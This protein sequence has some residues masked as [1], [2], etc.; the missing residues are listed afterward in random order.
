[1]ERAFADRPGRVLIVGATGSIGQPLFAACR[2]AGWSVVGTAFRQDRPGLLHFDLGRDVLESVLPGA[3]SG[4]LVYL[5]SALTSPNAVA[6]NPQSARELNLDASCR[7]ASEVL[8]SGARLV[9][10]SSTQVFDGRT[11]GY[12]E[13]SPCSALTLYGQL[14]CEFEAFLHSRDGDWAL[15][16]TDAIVTAAVGSNCPVEKTYQSLW[17]GGA[18]MACDN[19]L[20]LTAM[21]DFVS[22]LMRLALPCPSR[23]YHVAAQPPV[24]RAELAERIRSLSRFGGQMD[25]STIEFSDLQFPEP[26]PRATWLDARRLREELGMSFAF[27]KELVAQKVGMLDAE[28]EHRGPWWISNE[29]T[30]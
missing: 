6:Q 8:A 25:F 19:L 29:R 1:M 5:L 7:L 18:R 2:E 16:R 17:Q 11:G 4:D 14:K 27:P 10:I 20:S 24:S 23:L 28:V 26:R 22:V 21:D 9:A 30:G 13:E 12:T 3:G 15:I